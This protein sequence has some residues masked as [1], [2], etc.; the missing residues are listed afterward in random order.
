MVKVFCHEDVA[1]EEF[2]LLNRDLRDNQIRAQ[3][4]GGIMGPVMGN[5]SQVNYALTACIGGLL[6]VFRGFDV[7]GLS[8]FLN[9]SR[10]FS[11]PINEIS[12][13]VSNVFSALAGA[14]RV[15]AVMDEAPEPE[16]DKDAVTLAP[17]EAM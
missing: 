16:D 10:Q 11:R 17:M 15:F 4:F 12:M 9:F 3:F 6:C 14:E 7:G 8:V 1:A 13:Q 5:L 2:E